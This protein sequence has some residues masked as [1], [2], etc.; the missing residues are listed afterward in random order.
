MLWNVYVYF[1]FI[2][3]LNYYFVALFI[4][5]FFL[6][7]LSS[8]PFY[9]NVQKMFHFPICKPFCG[10]TFNNNLQFLSQFFLFLFRFEFK[11]EQAWQEWHGFYRND[12]TLRIAKFNVYHRSLFFLIK[13]KSWLIRDR[14]ENGFDSDERLQWASFDS[15]SNRLTFLGVRYTLH[16]FLVHLKRMQQPKL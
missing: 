12:L 1:N 9:R 10:P 3:Y 6:S 15:I 14:C 7:I 13:Y 11:S 4:C 16:L 2:I 5:F 8:F